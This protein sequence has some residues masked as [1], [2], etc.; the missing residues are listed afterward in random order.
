MTRYRE[1]WGIKNRTNRQQQG[2]NLLKA[3]DWGSKRETPPPKEEE[4]EG[5]EGESQGR[6]QTGTDDAVS[7]PDIEVHQRNT[8][9]MSTIGKPEKEGNS[10][11][12]RTSSRGN[13]VAETA[14][15]SKLYRKIDRKREKRKKRAQRKKN[16]NKEGSD[17]STSKS[18]NT[19]E[20]SEGK[21]ANLGFGV[22]MW[23]NRFIYNTR[24]KSSA[25]KAAYRQA[26]GDRAG[27]RPLEPRPTSWNSLRS[28]LINAKITAAFS[29]TNY[30]IHDK[31]FT[32]L[33]LL[34]EG[35]YSSVYEVYDEAKNLFALK[36]VKLTDMAKNAIFDNLMQEINFLV[37]LRNQEHVV[38]LLDYEHR[39]NPE[40]EEVLYMLLERGESDLNDI[41][42][43]LDQNKRLTPAKLRFYWEQML[44]AVLCVHRMRIVHGDIKPSN[45]IIVSGQLK[46]ID[47]GLAGEIKPGHHFIER[48]FIGGTKDYM[49]PESMAYYVITEGSLDFEEIKANRTVKIGYKADVWALGVILYQLTYGGQSPFANVPGGKLA[50]RKALMSPEHPVDF[51][52]VDDPLLLDT[53]KLC[54]RKNPQRRATVGRLLLHPFLHPAK[55]TPSLA[56]AHL[57]I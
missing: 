36:V 39:N 42:R 24:K 14:S 34:G 13:F 44:E 16:R 46:L 6:G 32:S 28:R 26:T 38:Q 45:F 9:K 53:M 35:G 52:P 20:R 54:L 25:R 31:K 30:F 8:S 49:S 33:R 55:L 23:I 15:N 47:F 40:D 27:S 48:E 56:R 18:G 11:D 57:Q 1:L 21:P 5:E 10:A 37:R 19:G 29:N 12:S 17:A 2:R 4:E 50:K 7:L 51:D 22:T 3:I 43:H 41:L